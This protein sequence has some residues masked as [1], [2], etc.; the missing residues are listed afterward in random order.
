[1]FDVGETYKEIYKQEKEFEQIS[2]LIDLEKKDLSRI[3]WLS[4]KTGMIGA[5]KCCIRRGVDPKG[6]DQVKKKC[7]TALIYASKYGHTPVVELLLNKGVDPNGIDQ[8]DGKAYQGN[9]DGKTALMFASRHGHTEVVEL[10]LNKGAKIDE[11][12][13]YGKTQ[14]V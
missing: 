5:V 12:N 11:A 9:Y 7:R 1:M 3:L 8:G 4:C 14:M 10:L 6:R 13:D 2:A